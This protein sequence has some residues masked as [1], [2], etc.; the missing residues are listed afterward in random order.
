MDKKKIIKLL[1]PILQIDEKQLTEI[2]ADTK[3]SE[4]GL[5]SI[6]FIQFIVA[7][8]DE[9][10][11]EILDSDLMMPKFETIEMLYQTL[12]KYFVGEN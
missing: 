2:S 5:D 1:I 11:I 4:L 12:E 3:L 8:E 7:L 9:F 10:N 6:R